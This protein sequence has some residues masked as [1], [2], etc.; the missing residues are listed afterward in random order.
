MA[1]K[2]LRF[3][4]LI[5]VSTEKQAAR[6]ESLKTQQRQIE[7]AVEGHDGQITKRYVGQ[8]HATAG[9]ERR[10][11]DQLLGEAQKER[12]PFDAVMVADASRWS[13]DNVANETGL[14]ILRDNGVRFFVLGMEFDLFDPMH[15]YMLSSQ[16][17]L[18][19]MV[20]K[21]RKQKSIL[22]C[23]HRAKRTGAPTGGKVPYGRIWNKEKERWEIDKEKQ[24]ILVDVAKRYLAGESM[25]KLA[26]EYGINHAFLHKTITKRS[27]DTHVIT[28]D[29]PD[30]NIKEEVV[31]KVPPL[32][33]AS[34]IKRILKKAE[35]NRTYQHGQAKYP[36]LLAGYVFCSGCEYS[37]HSQTNHQQTQ[38]YRHSRLPRARDCD[39][40]PRPWVRADELEDAVIRLL[41]DTFGNPAAVERAMEEAVPNL[42]KIKEF[43]ER[44][45][46]LNDELAKVER[47][48]NTILKLITREKLSEQQ[49]EEQLDELNQ[50]ES[51]LSEQMHALADSLDNSPS[52]E[53]IKATADEVVRRFTKVSTARRRAV[54][55]AAQ[56][57]FDAMTWDDKRALVEM[58]F[59][60][61]TPEGR[62]FGIYV[63]S[64]EGQKKRRR[65]QWAFQLIGIAPLNGL[66]GL[67]P[68]ST[69]EEHEPAEELIDSDFAEDAEAQCVTQSLSG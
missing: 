8:E 50:R 11:L 64:I 1:N 67:C 43:R 40:D 45:D 56:T 44:H 5:R 55:R 51:N 16:A 39:L 9:Y 32:L 7:S 14:D 25:P 61:R 26:E 34:T 24:A 15:R 59:N 41:F 65:K 48:R 35:A 49:A 66:R 21:L 18:N 29:I 42:E 12:K 36:Y 27:G 28:W 20:A 60:G 10:L 52:P 68:G 37:L 33:P 54:A 69:N 22:S 38:Y 3:G 31:I 2:K 46:R 62:P 47:S 53:Q 57:D 23:I 13:R 17:T 58:V 6:G 19:Q 30:L 4:I 63:E